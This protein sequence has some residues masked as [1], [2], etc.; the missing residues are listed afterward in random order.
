MAIVHG[1]TWNLE[2]IDVAGVC[3][4]AMMD[5]FGTFTEIA[6]KYLDRNGLL[7]VDGKGGRWV[8]RDKWYP[9]ERWL[10]AYDEI[11]KEVHARVAFDVGLAIP[12]NAV[13]PPHIVDIES[14]LA[15]LDIAYHMNHR[16]N[17]V[18]MFDPK[19]GRLADGIGNY[20]YKKTPNKNRAEFL[21]DNVYPCD[22]DMG[23][24]TGMAKRFVPTAKVAHLAEGG[25]RRKNNQSCTYVVTW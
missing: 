7:E 2:G 11:I 20:I 10:K 19:T 14:S 22:L 13:F 18:V 4:G 15:S 5:G 23:I 9:I 3:I 16:K 17:G 24:V 6:M 21:C 8:N 25:C 12:K 1:Q